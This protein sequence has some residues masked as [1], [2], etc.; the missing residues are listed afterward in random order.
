MEEVVDQ[1]KTQNAIENVFDKLQASCNGR[2]SS[3]SAMEVV[4]KLQWRSNWTAANE[5]V[6]DRMQRKKYLTNCN[7]GSSWTGAME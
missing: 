7:E 2:S 3:P 4:D 1:W 6:V 5:E